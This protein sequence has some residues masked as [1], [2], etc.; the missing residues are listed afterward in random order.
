MFELFASI[1]LICSFIGMGIMIF[2]KIPVLVE[3]PEQAV[4]FFNWQSFFLKIKET[5]LFKRFSSDIF[6]QKILSKIR[7]FTLKT[8]NKTSSLLQRMREKNQQ[9]K[10]GKNDNYWKDIKNSIDKD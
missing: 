1:I 7:V 3:L 4:P 6:F 10:F 8:D 9:K 2:R 5:K